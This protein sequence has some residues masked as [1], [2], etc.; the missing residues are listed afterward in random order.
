VPSLYPTQVHD[1]GP[2]PV[3]PVEVPFMHR[4]MVGI[5]EKLEP[6]A[7]PQE[8][9]TRLVDVVRDMA[10]GKFHKTGAPSY[11]VLLAKSKLG[12]V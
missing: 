3:T 9:F 5:V 1:H 10:Y 11:P 8:P 4:L 6:F 12:E 2:V 7:V